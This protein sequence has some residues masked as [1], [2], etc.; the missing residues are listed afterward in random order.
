MNLKS[1]IPLSIIF[2][3]LSS[4][5]S[6]K[7]VVSEAK[8]V[9]QKDLM[10]D[11]V[12][13]KYKS[14]ITSEE[15]KDYLYTLASNDFEGRET[16]TRGGKMAA[17]FLSDEYHRL[18]LKGPI[19]GRAN[20]Y[21]QSIP[22]IEM[23]TTYGYITSGDLQLDEGTDFLTQY[24]SGSSTAS[25]VVFVGHGIELPDYN[26]YADIDVRGKAICAVWGNPNNSAG[27]RLFNT[28]QDSF[29][30]LANLAK[31]GITDLFITMPNQRRYDAQKMFLENSSSQ[32]Q[33]EFLMD[34]SQLQDRPYNLYFISPASAARLFGVTSDEF[35]SSV[36]KRLDK[37]ETLGGIFKAE[38][39]EISVE[40]PLKN[41][42]CENVIAFVEGTDLKDEV[43]V[44]S[45]H[46]D[47]V[48]IIDGKI[49]NGA[50]DDGSGTVGVLEIA[51]AFATAAKDGYSPR[52]SVVFLNVTGE[53]KGLFGSQ[54]YTDKEPI[55]P[56]ENTIAN[57]NIDMIG[58]VDKRHEDSP[59]YVYIIGSDMLSTELH[60]V[61]E[62]VAKTYFPEMEMDYL[63]NGK[64]HPDRFYYR[65]D[66]YNFA[67]NNIP[68]IFYF[69][70]THDDY[71][72]HTDTPD[73][74]EYDVLKQR[75]QL[76]FTTAWHLANGQNRPV[77]DVAD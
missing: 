22:F 24:S 15:L 59:E 39:V 64:T 65:S 51:E 14:T 29:L 43:I 61:H 18:G 63:Y 38:N 23:K 34:E 2:V 45:S 27:K 70:G 44:I 13:A 35:F 4:C 69:N 9:P 16:G 31:K 10:N 50:D 37:K 26:D 42:D 40:R 77:V 30:N 75:T 54:Y 41:I 48:G 8:A 58:R 62:Q 56:L 57:L 19:E 36:Q 1:L 5:I 73:K 49:Y 68:V 66:H 25:E 7:Q 53:E 74:I 55:F 21:L 71:H 52:R 67:K 20:E 3:I 11:A 12:I 6:S 17:Q 46:Y 47:H 32:F 72:K 28:A 76:I 60:R 33:P